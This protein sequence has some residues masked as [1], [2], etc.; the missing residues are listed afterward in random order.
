MI[1]TLQLTNDFN[2]SPEKG[3]IE[4]INIEAEDLHVVVARARIILSSK[5]FKSTV[6]GFRVLAN[7]DR[8]IYL[9]RRGASDISDIIEPPHD[10]APASRRGSESGL[11]AGG[12]AGAGIG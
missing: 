3:V 8:V 12:Q 10:A 4:A 2:A 5:D 6:D 9:E 1:F 11:R 7:G